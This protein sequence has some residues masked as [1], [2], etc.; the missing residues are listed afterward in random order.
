[1][2]L[3]LLPIGAYE[4]R[5]FMRGQHMNPRDAVR[6]HLDLRAWHSMGIHFGTWRLTDEGF[7]EP[8]RALTEARREKAVADEDFFLLET[9]ESRDVLLRGP[10]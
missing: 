7:D 3:A 8:V 10:T 5:W 6:A 2:D 1:M 4:P 9:G